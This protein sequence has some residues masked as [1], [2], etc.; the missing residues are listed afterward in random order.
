MLTS[1]PGWGAWGGQQWGEGK[2]DGRKINRSIIYPMSFQILWLSLEFLS[3]SV[4]VIPS[5]WNATQNLR[6]VLKS[7]CR[8]HVA[9]FLFLHNS[10]QAI[11]NLMVCHTTQASQ[12]KQIQLVLIPPSKLSLPWEQAWHLNVCQD[13]VPLHLPSSSGE[14]TLVQ[15]GLQTTQSLMR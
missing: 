13:Q 2:M 5:L 6:S 4:H 14:Y 8:Y 12:I 15:T 9:G 1:P 7:V 3:T 11:N 10:F